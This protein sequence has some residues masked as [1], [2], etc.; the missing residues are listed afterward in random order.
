MVSEQRKKEYNRKHQQLHGKED[1]QRRKQYFAEHPDEYE[2]RLAYRRK[3]YRDNREK[4][5]VGQ[6]KWYEKQKENPEFLE[7]K[8]REGRQYYQKTRNK[9]LLRERIK[10]DLIKRSV[11]QHYSPEL[12]C[13]MCGNSDIR[14]LS[15]DHIHGG[16]SNHY[17]N[18]RS[19]GT[20][21]YRWL[22]KNDYPEGYQVLCM[23]CNFIKAHEN[24]EYTGKK[25]REKSHD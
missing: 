6:K 4:A 23:N 18:L 5:R 9:Q 12:K 8:R 24:H 14:V 25:N 3:W 16:G 11:L 17:R 10:R 15:I 2:K 22:I 1:Y 13:V 20:T 7:N 21:L 19:Q